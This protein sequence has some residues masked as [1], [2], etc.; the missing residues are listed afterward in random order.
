LYRRKL[1]TAP[2]EPQTD[3]AAYI[4]QRIAAE[5]EFLFAVVAEALGSSIA[6]EREAAA[7]TLR[8]QVRYGSQNGF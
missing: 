5:R 6:D 3:W 2:A 4:E 1:D 8:D 7:Q